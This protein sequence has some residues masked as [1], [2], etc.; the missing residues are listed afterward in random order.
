MGQFPQDLELNL[1]HHHHHHHSSI[2]IS[3]FPRNQIPSLRYSQEAWCLH[4]C[5]CV[6]AAHAYG[7]T[8]LCF[9]ATIDVGHSTSSC[10]KGG[11]LMDLSFSFFDMKIKKIYMSEC[12]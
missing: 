9:V 11:W 5:V 1:S 6:C 12:K 3:I 10:T 4:A 8:T 7:N 2:N